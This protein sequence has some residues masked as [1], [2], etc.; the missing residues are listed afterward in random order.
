MLTSVLLVL[1]SLVLL[2]WGAGR[3]VDGASATATHLGI[4][5]LLVGIL[6]VGFGTSAPEMFVSGFAAWNGN[7]GLGY[8]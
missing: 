3:F 1:L 6:F 8:G 5:P 2:F 4:S 7:P